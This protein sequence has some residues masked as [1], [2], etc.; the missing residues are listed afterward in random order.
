MAHL[1][2]Y[3]TKYININHFMYWT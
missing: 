3:H 1:N 2:K